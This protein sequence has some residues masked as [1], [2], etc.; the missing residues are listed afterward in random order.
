MAI[1][2]LNHMEDVDYKHEFLRFFC[3]QFFRNPVVH[4]KEKEA[5][6]EMKK[7]VDGLTNLNT[8]FYVNSLLIFLTE[9]MSY[10]INTNM[11]SCI[12]IYVNSKPSIMSTRYQNTQHFCWV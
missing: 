11:S 5:V 3:M 10:N 6:D 4:K 9:Q 7:T 1:T 8:N 2:A 12:E